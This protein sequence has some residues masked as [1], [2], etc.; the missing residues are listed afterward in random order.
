[1]KSSQPFT[2]KI[3]ANLFNKLPRLWQRPGFLIGL[4][5][6]IYL[7]VGLLA[8]TQYSESVDEPHRMQYAESSLDAYFGKIEDLKDEKGPFYSMF[9]LLGSKG[10][11][12]LFP[13]WKP[14][15][16]WHYMYFVSFVIGVYFFYRLC[17]RLIDPAPAIAAT[18]LFGTQPLLWGHAFINPKD[19][20]FMAFF[21]ASVSLGL[22][23]VDHMHAQLD[24]SGGKLSLQSELSDLRRKLAGDWASASGR[25]RR[26]LVGLSLL[27][28]V[29]GLSY[30][31]VQVL[32]AGLVRQAYTA[33]VTSWLGRLFRRT[34]VYAGQI[35]VQ[36]YI[37][38][39]QRLYSRVELFACIGLVLACVCVALL[40]FPSVRNRLARLL[41]QP[42]V[43]LAGCFLGFCSDIRTL[44]PA[45]GLLVAVYF[46][47]KSGRKA[48]PF[49]LEYLGVGALTIYAFWPYLWQDPFNRFWSSLTEAADFPW[50]GQIMFAGKIYSEGN[51]PTSYLPVLFTLQF[52]ETAMALILIGIILAGFY[53]VRR[54]NLRMDMLL[55]G[56]WF[57]APVAAAILLHST[58]YNN[59]RQFLFVV[60]PLFVF[61][62]L[63]LQALWNRLTRRGILFIPLVILMILPGLYWDWQLHPYQYM[64][65]NSLVGGVA[66]AF[67]NYD[68]DYWNS[69]YKDAIEYVNR[70]APENATVSFWTKKRTAVPYARSDLELMRITNTYDPGYPLNTLTDYAVITTEDNVDQICF[71][72]SKE[73]YKVERGGAVLAVVKQVNK[74]D[75]ILS[76]NTIQWEEP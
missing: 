7:A 19:I 67:R 31:L 4:M 66:G 76:N 11:A 59:F 37:S 12:H 18:L 10:L 24:A 72:A 27:L 71:P 29:L 21:L 32:L 69:G 74:G 36:D 48:I 30:R 75:L 63:A 73:I 26:L 38:K 50:A 46:L 15:D 6:I 16:G 28:V 51:Q 2:H 57:V 41:A 35:P 54:A 25:L 23:M 52:T 49:L 43:L 53:L 3:V 9:A 33:P 22:E 64:Y 34:A 70:V 61:A 42:R 47:Y 40:I 5:T 45:S 62:G 56:V 14:I 8:V 65:Y 55:L 13:G 39:A 20:P 44:G 58:V 1:M 60:P 17:R 68:T